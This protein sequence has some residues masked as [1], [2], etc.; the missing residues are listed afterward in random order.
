MHVTCSVL[1]TLKVF[2]GL[3]PEVAQSPAFKASV[4]SSVAFALNVD[5]SEVTINSVT[6]ATSRRALLAGRVLLS[7]MLSLMLSRLMAM[8]RRKI[9]I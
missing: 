6:L 7:L 2:S 9:L 1:H 4:Q 5:P 8:G 3:T